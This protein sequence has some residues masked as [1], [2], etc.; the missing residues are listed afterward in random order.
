M[1]LQVDSRLGQNNG[2]SDM[3]AMLFESLLIRVVLGVVVS[4]KKRFVLQA[5]SRFLDS[6]P[7]RIDRMWDD[8]FSRERHW[9]PL[10]LL[11]ENDENFK[12]VLEKHSTRFTTNPFY[13]QKNPAR[14]L[15]RH[16]ESPFCE[17]TCAGNKRFFSAGDGILV[18]VS[19]YKMQ[20]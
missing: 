3:S 6:R 9:K 16:Y 10:S 11:K 2:Q 8:F 20:K 14:G 5:S 1:R 17:R 18:K 19:L 7:R 12:I 15:I 13:C 4:S